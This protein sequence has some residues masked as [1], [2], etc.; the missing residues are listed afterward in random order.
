M[1]IFSLRNEKLQKMHAHV[2]ELRSFAIMVLLG[3][4]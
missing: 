2:S 3:L 4:L 1:R